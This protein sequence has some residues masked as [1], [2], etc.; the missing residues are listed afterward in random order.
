MVLC[1]RGRPV[2]GVALVDVGEL[3][4]LVGRDLDRLCK[5]A[6]LSAIVVVGRS[7]VEGQDMTEGV[8]RHVQLGSTL[9]LAP[10]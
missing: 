7:D 5:A 3:D 8:D 9:R 10:S 1:G 6:H 2:A 4:T